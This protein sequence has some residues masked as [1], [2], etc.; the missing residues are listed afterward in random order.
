MS[1]GWAGGGVKKATAWQG[2]HPL[3]GFSKAMSFT[4]PFWTEMTLSSR[5]PPS[6]SLSICPSSHLLCPYVLHMLTASALLCLAFSDQT[7]PM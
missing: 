5:P 2:Q 1:R 3:L 7:E 6:Q 4:F